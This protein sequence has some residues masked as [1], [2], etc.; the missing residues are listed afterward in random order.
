MRAADLGIAIGTGTPGP[1]DAITD[2]EGVAVGH[3]TLIEGDAIR[4]GVT[5]VV[6]D[7]VWERA[8]FA[9]SFRLN[10]NGEMTGLEL[11]REFGLLTCPIAITNT[12][13][14]GVVRDAMV[15]V[16][17]EDG[18]GGWVLPIVAETWDGRLNDINGQHVRAEHLRAAMA[19]ASGGP[20]AEGNV[21]GGTG[22]VC[23]GF[24][25]G[26]GTASRRGAR[27][28]G[29]RARAGQ[30]RRRA[31]ACSSTARRSGAALADVPAPTGDG[32]P[33]AG[34]IIVI[35][36][37]D[38]PLLPHQCDR[39]AQRAS[40]GIARTGG[41]GEHSSGDLL[42]AF[43]TGNRPLASEEEDQV[44]LTQPLTMLSDAHFDPLGV[45]RDRGDRGGDPQRDARRRDDDRAGRRDRARAP[46]RPA[47][48]GTGAARS[49]R[50]EI[51]GVGW[52][53]GLSG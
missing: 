26:I 48:R 17:V 33:G 41:A 37:T 7:G 21:G 44:P 32:P 16:D 22:M 45:R 24:K 30:P 53:P 51:I 47:R 11:V 27:L 1:L 50:D 43:A 6:P 8:P 36:A 28:H 35:V 23:H 49:A 39:L 25:G 9:G 42:L 10:G 3:C 40:L 29:R 14:V 38:A 31:S 15:T 19:G 2:V 4:T 12:H 5:V 13:S 52:T 18:R 46:A 34:S 20:V